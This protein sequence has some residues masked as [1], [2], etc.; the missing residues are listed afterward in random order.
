MEGGAALAQLWAG[1]ARSLDDRPG[2]KAHKAR[3]AHEAREARKAGKARKAWM[4]GLA[5]KAREA[6][7][8]RKARMTGLA[9]EA[10]EARS[11]DFLNSLGPQHPALLFCL[12]RGTVCPVCPT[13]PPVRGARA[14]LAAGVHSWTD[15]A[16]GQ[17]TP[18]AP[19]DLTSP[20][21]PGRLPHPQ[22]G[23]SSH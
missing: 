23:P 1:P 16:S 5:R 3:K 21:S 8:A 15:A 19:V 4:T 11:P 18:R 10:R 2:H 17:T 9:R 7:E 6:R 13:P 14:C 20:R 22:A 12:S